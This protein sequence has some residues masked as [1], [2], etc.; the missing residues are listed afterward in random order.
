MS[1]LDY[2]PDL[3][4]SV[5]RVL[6]ASCP[7]ARG[8]QRYDISLLQ[9][10]QASSISSLLYDKKSCNLYPISENSTTPVLGSANGPVDEIGA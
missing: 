7:G 8:K 10:E 2:F 3:H 1:F 4:L 9:T 6:S 5:W